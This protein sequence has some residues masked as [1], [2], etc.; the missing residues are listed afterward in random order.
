MARVR[1]TI[2]RG[3]GGLYDV[4]DPKP[5]YLVESWALPDETGN[6]NSNGLIIGILY[7]CKKKLR[8]TQ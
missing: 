7:S 3:D 6:W 1:L 2:F 8:H 5:N 4:I